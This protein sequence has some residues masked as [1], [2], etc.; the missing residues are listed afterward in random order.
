MPADGTRERRHAERRAL[1]GMELL[2][3]PALNKGTAFSQLE[4]ET[5]GLEGL[6]PTRVLTLEQQA[7]RVLENFRRKR[8]DLDKYI[9]MIALQERNETLFFRVVVDNIE[10]MMPILYTPTVGQ[11]CQQYAHIFRRPQGLFLP[12]ETRGHVARLLA[13]WPQ[14]DV[15]VIVV[16]D[17]ERI[18]GLGDLGANGMGIP[19]GKLTLYS[20]IAGVHP[21]RCLPVL[22]DVGTNNEALLADP[23][24]F[25]SLHPRARG[26][27]YHE[28]VQEFL[29]A[30]STRFPNA[31]IQ[32]EDFA[33]IH[34][35][36]LLEQSRHRLRTFNDDIQ[37]TGAVVLAGLITAARLRDQRARRRAAAGTATD[38]YPAAFSELR[39]LFVGTGEASLGSGELLTAALRE[40][41]LSA[42]KARDCCWFVDSKGL[43]VAS[44]Q[45]LSDH[46][47]QVAQ[48]GPPLAD[49]VEII[50]HVRPNAIVGTTGTAGVF[51]EQVVRAM[52]ALHEQP[53]VFALSNPTAKAEC[54]AEQ[55]YRW[56]D[57]RAIFAGGSPF[58]A[59]EWE[60][61][62]HT[63]GQA[64]NVYVF[65]AVGLGALVSGAAHVTDAMF[66][67]AARALAAAVDPADLEAGRIFPPLQEIREV[68]VEVAAAV[69]EVAY[70]TGAATADAAGKRP[71]DLRAAVAA[72]MY[73]P[74]Y[75]PPL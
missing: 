43:V 37:G 25:G 18:L 21:T 23:L 34:A 63:P 51:T 62:T 19:V 72:A 6:L 74:D 47:R 59:V 48:E 52:S 73:R 9:F 54:T 24:Y 11:A 7:E 2:R 45:D 12:I 22:L 17:G 42:A 53:I 56:S 67:S 20:A 50:G 32:F 69:A 46:K 5:L 70:A 28:F 29:T 40:A 16:T 13:N 1:H 64:N 57:G 68:T 49:L 4:R 8:S 66:L 61:R 38:V 30:A 27:E 31:I 26:A 14:E 65:P 39:V 41:G 36:D 33:N 15:Q 71:A 44:R 55:A 75:A 58:A 10:E 3:D 35:F 60:G